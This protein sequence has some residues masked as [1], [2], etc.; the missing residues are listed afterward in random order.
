MQ[1]RKS[2]EQIKQEILQSLNEKPLS[3]EQLRKKVESNWSTVNIYLE[4]LKKEKKVKELIS[5]KKEKIYQLNTPDTYF[6]LPLSDEQR[7]KFRT[8]FYLIVKT[9][10]DENRFPTKTQIAKCA[11][12]VI[13]QES[14]LSDLPTIS[15]LHGTIPILVASP[16]EKYSQEIQLKNQLRIMKIIQ[17]YVKQN[18]RKTSRQIDREQHLELGDELYN[19]SDDFLIEINKDKP[20]QEELLDILNKLFIECPVDSDFPEVFHYADRFIST[21]NK[22][23]FFAKLP[24]YKKEITPCF[25]ALWNYLA[26]YKAYQSIKSKILPNKEIILEFYIGNMMEARKTCFEENFSELESAYLAKL[27]EPSSNIENIELDKDIIEIRKIMEG[28]TGED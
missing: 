14:S 11:V 8:L 18:C 27:A 13:N 9:Y 25:Q 16:V 28:W 2:A 22:L 12:R 17:E 19:L 6:N 24:D 3:I 20:S 15:Y 7:K 21:L 1:I 10:K 4:E 5:T 23:S 26:T